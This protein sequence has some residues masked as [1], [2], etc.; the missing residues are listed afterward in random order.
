MLQHLCT[1][2][3]PVAVCDTARVFFFCVCVSVEA[4]GNACLLNMCICVRR[5]ARLCTPPTK[6][7][8]MPEGQT[9]RR[10]C[11]LLGVPVALT[12]LARRRE[13][14]RTLR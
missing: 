7:P 8:R 4:N 6:E 5:Y 10:C 2:F 3:M 14:C 9:S 1:S 11:F 13:Q 12:E